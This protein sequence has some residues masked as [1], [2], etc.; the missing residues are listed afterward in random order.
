MVLLAVTTMALAGC[1]RK[2]GLDLPSSAAAPVVEVEE[3]RAASQGS[4]FAP[5]GADAGPVAAKGAKRAFILD[6]LLN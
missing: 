4:V 1:G 3:E 2:G 6:P 5:Q